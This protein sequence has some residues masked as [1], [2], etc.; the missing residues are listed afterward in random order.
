MGA[1]RVYRV[2]E[3]LKAGRR[4]ERHRF[5]PAG[6]RVITERPQ[7]RNSDL[8]IVRDGKNLESGFT[9]FRKIHAALGG[10][11]IGSELTLRIKS[12]GGV[13]RSFVYRKKSA[14]EYVLVSRAAAKGE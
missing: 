9:R 10:K 5:W 1:K 7:R 12:A 11:P 13:V 6:P 14:E 2:S 8:Q 4:V 3:F